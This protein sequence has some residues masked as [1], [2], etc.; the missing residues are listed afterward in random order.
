MLVMGCD[1][2]SSPK[3]LLENGW[4]DPEHVA[5]S[6]ALHRAGEAD[7]SRELSAVLQVQVWDEVFRKGRS[8]ED[9]DPGSGVNSGARAPAP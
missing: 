4:F 3:S 8:L 2:L 1:D 5:R 7:R 9:F 6:R